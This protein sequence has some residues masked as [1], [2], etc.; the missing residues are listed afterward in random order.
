MDNTKR[1]K[2]PW[3]YDT[4][5]VHTEIQSIVR[6]RLLCT[7]STGQVLVLLERVERSL[8]TREN[9]ANKERNTVIT[10]VRMENNNI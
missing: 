10:T 1:D 2:Q 3:I 6:V 9:G 7:S 8:Y 4:T 5:V